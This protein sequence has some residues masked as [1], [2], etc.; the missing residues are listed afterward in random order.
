MLSLQTLLNQLRE[1]LELNPRRLLSSEEERILLHAAKEGSAEAIEL[2]IRCNRGLVRKMAWGFLKHLPWFCKPIFELD[3]LIQ[4]GNLGLATAIKKFDFEKG[5]KLST[6]AVWWIRQRIEK[7]IKDKSRL[8]KVPLH[9]LKKQA[10]VALSIASFSVRYGREP[11]IGEIVKETGLKA[12]DVKVALRPE[13]QLSPLSLNA[14]VKKDEETE[15]GDLIGKNADF[16][17]EISSQ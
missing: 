5:E 10:A 12:E 7:A 13:L 11:T 9:F 2:L 8:V 16:D 6:Y 4:D 14:K 1:E 17:G 15:L 3:D